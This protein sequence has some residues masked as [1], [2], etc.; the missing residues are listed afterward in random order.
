MK[1]VDKLSC[2]RGPVPVRHISATAQKLYR[3][4][5]TIGAQVFENSV[6]V[7]ALKWLKLFDGAC[8]LRSCISL[9]ILVRVCVA[10]L[11]ACEYTES[12]FPCHMCEACM[13]ITEQ[14]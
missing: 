7:R 9:S 10:Y 11:T 8:A 2:A 13:H 1:T 3:R 12:G 4:T 6:Y 14:A 5:L